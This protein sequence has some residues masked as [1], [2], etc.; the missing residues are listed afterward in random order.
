MG[1][2]DGIVLL[3]ESASLSTYIAAY[4]TKDQG[5][6]LSSIEIFGGAATL[7]ERVETAALGHLG[8]VRAAEDAGAALIINADPLYAIDINNLAAVAGNADYVFVGVVDDEAGTTYPENGILYT[9]Y[10]VDV[11]MQ[12]K[13]DLGTDEVSI[14]KTGGL[15]QDGKSLLII[16]EDYLP[17]VGNAYVF[18][19]YA[20]P[21]GTLRVGGK[22]S[23][24]LLPVANAG[25]LSVSELMA[26][27]EDT[28]TYA[29]F[30]DACENE[31]PIDR[32]RSTY[33]KP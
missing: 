23:N 16:T 12:L 7:S 31:V 27:V 9:G 19:A 20:Q 21:D 11:I 32:D 15:S 29:E 14:A 26:S 10:S 22:N 2:R 18:V 4:I 17:V 13:G 25:S 8:L 5:F 30:V 1:A 28:Q 24:I 3:S 6:P 33:I